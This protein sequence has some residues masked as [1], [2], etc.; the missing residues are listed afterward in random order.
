MNIRAQ[1]PRPRKSL[2]Q[3]F[4]QDR[5]LARK[6]VEALRVTSEDRVWE[7]GPGPGILTAFL[8]QAAP[9][10]LTLLEKDAYWAARLRDE[11]AGASLSS[12]PMVLTG[13]ALKQNWRDCA[14]P[15]K[16]IGNLPYNIA[17]PLMWKLLSEAGGLS[18]A[19]FMLQKEVGERVTAAASSGVYGA[20]SVWIQLFC[21]PRLEFIVPP[22]V[23][24]PRPKVYSAVL[25]F[26]PLPSEL[27]PARP[28]ALSSLL[29]LLFQQRRKQVGVILRAR[30]L[31]PELPQRCGID[32]ACRPENISPAQYKELS[33][34]F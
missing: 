21:R 5:N 34:I 8:L 22:Q 19:V 7:I 6:I 20:L 30:G 1:C 9:A 18:R 32:P 14:A 16:V 23:F 15:F 29:K 12:A 13:D 4:L 31:D 3:N 27:R 17:S 2:G 26:D 25:S 28:E 10:S 33:E 24:R 11:T